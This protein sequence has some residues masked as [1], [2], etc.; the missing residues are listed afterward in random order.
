MVEYLSA[1]FKSPPPR[2]RLK[3]KFDKLVLDGVRIA[4]TGSFTQP[5]DNDFSELG[6]AFDLYTGKITSDNLLFV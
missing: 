5:K 2:T 4:I 6:P 1:N 3:C